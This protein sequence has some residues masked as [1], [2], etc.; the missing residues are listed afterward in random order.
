MFD[1]K[2]ENNNMVII[3]CISLFSL[4]YMIHTNVSKEL[5]IKSYII[6]NY[7]YIFFAFL[8]IILLNE[9]KLIPEMRNS[10]KIFALCILMFI[11]I[12]LI[13]TTSSE[14]QLMKHFYWLLLICLF[15]VLLQPI[16]E[17]IKNENILNKVLISTSVMFIVMTYIAYNKPISYYDSWFPYL[18]NGLLGIIIV[19]LTNIIFSDLDNPSN[20]LNR[21]WIISVITILLFNGFLLYDTQKIIKEGILLNFVCKNKNHL[22]C[23]D[24]P[25]KSLAMIL[26]MINLFANVSNI[27]SNN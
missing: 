3:L 23:A 27:Y 25:E 8:F 1:K 2:W 22:S 9:K 4:I 21:G 17:K 13:N 16:Y 15:A 26:D 6:T 12:M 14:N 20:F 18:Y 10:I 11:L 24:Y 5:T 7:M 19:S